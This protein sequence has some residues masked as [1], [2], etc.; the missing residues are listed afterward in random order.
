[1][2]RQGG[3][4]RLLIGPVLLLGLWEAASRLELVNPTF[5]PAPTEIVA[6][7]GVLFDSESDLG[8][9]VVDT[10]VR[11]LV[12]AV[13]AA[14]LGIG[15]G[16]AMASFQRAA[17]GV[18]MVLSFFYPIPAILF[19]PMVSFVAGRGETTIIATALVT[20]YIVIAVY[21]IVGIRQIDRV[22]IEAGRNFGARGWR[23]LVRLLV[24]GA[25]PVIVAGIRVSLGFALISV[26]ATEMVAASTGLGAYLW[27]SWQVLRVTDMYVALVAV[28]VLGLLTSVGFD[29]IGNRLL[30]W[31]ADRGGT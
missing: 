30:P 3:R 21:T 7:A 13:L 23:Y 27:Q 31:R 26:V 20:P 2:R 14:L 1:V 8:A 18:E 22:L 5:F 17:R 15:T 29:A 6:Q 28:A 12:T 25:L 19:L 16:L 9:G 10:V 11:L 24:P 4:W